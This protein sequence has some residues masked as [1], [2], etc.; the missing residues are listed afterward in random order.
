MMK[1]DGEVRAGSTRCDRCG[2]VGSAVSGHVCLCKKHDQKQASAPRLKSAAD[3]LASLHK[4]N[5]R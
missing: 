2:A 5:R 3:S 4:A 1:K